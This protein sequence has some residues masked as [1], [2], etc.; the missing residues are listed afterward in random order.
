MYRSGIQTHS[1][2]GHIVML[3][4]CQVAVL[5]TWPMYLVAYAQPSTGLVPTTACKTSIATTFVS[6]GIPTSFRYV[7]HLPAGENL[8][9]FAICS[10]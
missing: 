1:D 5:P 7:V 10:L 4:S 6:E 2:I 3:I 8:T 9:A